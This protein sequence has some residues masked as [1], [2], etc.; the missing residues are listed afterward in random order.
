MS[1]YG[2]LD[3]IREIKEEVPTH[4]SSKYLELEKDRPVMDEC[5]LNSLSSADMLLLEAE[6]SDLEIKEAV[7]DCEG[8]KSP[9]PDGYNFTFIRNCWHFMK[10]DISRFIKDFH[11]KAKLSKS[12]TSSFLSLVP[13][14]MNPLSL[15]DY[16]PIFLVGCLHKIISKLLD[17]CLKRVLDELISR[18]QSTFIHGR[19]MLDKVL[20]VNE[21]VDFSTRENKQ[22]LLFKVDFEKA[23][24]KVN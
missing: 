10:V 1:D 19:Q 8:A 20:I 16:C 22:C 7:W 9:G 17:V 13:K 2:L 11:S 12:I 15:D 4:F 5:L 14:K 3:G 23:Y 6:F 18:N 21:V 24:D